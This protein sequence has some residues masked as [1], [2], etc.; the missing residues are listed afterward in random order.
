MIRL[1]IRSAY[2]KEDE[3]IPADL[4]KKSGILQNVLG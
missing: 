3:D 4:H 2:G 1:N